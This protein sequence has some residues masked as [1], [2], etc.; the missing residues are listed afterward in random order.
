MSTALLFPFDS[1]KD[2]LPRKKFTRKDVELMTAYDFFEGQRYELINGDVID[3]V[4]QKP[5]R[6]GNSAPYG[7]LI[8]VFQALP[9]THTDGNG[10]GARRQQPQRS[11]A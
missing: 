4:G 7:R 10:C 5:A 3:K 8:Q 9:G 1:A 2:A 11:C 6:V